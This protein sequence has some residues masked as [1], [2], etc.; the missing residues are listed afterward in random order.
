LTWF[1]EA[2]SRWGVEPA[3]DCAL[4][5]YLGEQLER[6]QVEVLELRLQVVDGPR[7]RVR[8][9]ERTVEILNGRLAAHNGSKGNK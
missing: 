8:E 2:L 3:P 6:A 4:C 7:V 1:L 9:L 5:V